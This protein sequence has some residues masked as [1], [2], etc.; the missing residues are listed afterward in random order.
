MDSVTPSIP[1]SGPADAAAP[2]PAPGAQNTSP[3]EPDPVARDVPLSAVIEAV[4]R[5]A[6]RSTVRLGD[7]IDRTADR[8]Y[9]LLLVLLG[10]PMLIPFLPPGSSTVVGPLYAA[11]AV[12]MLSGTRRPWVPRRFRNWVL[13]GRTL[14]ALRR[15]G[16]PLVRFIERF[17]RPR[18][19]RVNERVVLRASGVMIFLMG[20]VLLSPLPLMNTVPAIS[21]MLMGIGLLNRDAL[22]MLAGLLVGVLS[23]AM[24]GV[25]AG[26]L[27]VW[28]QRILSTMSAP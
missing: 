5:D 24:I 13:T 3:P 23:L 12:Q 19:T 20:L 18:G 21:V 9:G 25:T 15:R 14:E 7:L 1:A 28:I 2:P 10:L 26:L 16:V 4:L 6:E 22:F 17:S 8:G 11:F 27:V